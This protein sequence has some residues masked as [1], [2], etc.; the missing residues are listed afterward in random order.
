MRRSDHTVL[1]VDD[2]PSV[3]DS[4]RWTLTSADL[5]PVET[6]SDPREVLDHVTETTRVVLLDLVMPHK[7]GEE[8]LAEVREAHPE[9]QVVV[10]T[11]DARVETVVRCVQ[12]GAADFLA[13]PVHGE[14][15]VSR[16]R[17]ALEQCALRTEA[18]ELRERWQDPTPRNPAAFADILTHDPAMRRIFAYLEVV[19]PSSE[20]VLITGET[21][22]GKEL[23]ARAL[24]TCSRRRGPFVA[25]SVAGL[26]ETL[27]SDTLFGHVRGAYTGSEGARR[28]AMERAA[29]GTIFLDEI[30]DLSE[31]SQLKLL[32][33]LQ[34]REFHP[35][36]SDQPVP[37]RARVVAATH[38]PKATLRPDL[39]YRLRGYQV[40]MP[41]L[42]ERPADL[43]PLLEH[44]VAQAATDL[45]RAPPKV[46]AGLVRGLRSY[47]FPGNVRELRALAFHGVAMAGRSLELRD[48][49][50]LM[51]GGHTPGD[52]LPELGR[53]LSDDEMTELRRRN[54]LRAL[55]QT[56]WRVSGP[57]GAAELLGVAPTTLASRIKRLG[58]ER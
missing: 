10:V 41:P 52:D 24:H 56:R 54:I 53:V 19:A 9:V 17:R 27:F 5:G 31:P 11:S 2:D 49:T 13:K 25:V 21:G 38:R 16:V 23:A 55:E 44:F 50:H 45:R 42:R 3:L 37:L 39:Y 29:G 6:C 18:S 48:V 26:D 58:I 8:V 34:E 46:G 33:V 28:G 40:R 57:G 22:T 32:R 43:A 51:E 14:L 7:S 4:V 15:L 1:V 12:A 30:G 20:P 35:L 47:P 36:G